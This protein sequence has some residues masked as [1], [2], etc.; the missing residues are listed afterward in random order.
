MKIVSFRSSGKVGHFLRAE[1]NR[2]GL[3]YPVPPRTSLLG[4]VGAIL[5]LEKD[6]P[7]ETL[8]GAALA[9][10]GRIP[11]I[12]WHTV[13]FRKDPPVPLPLAVK[14]TVNADKRI[15]PEKAALIPQEWLWCPDFIV[16]AALPDPYHD[17]FVSRL[18]E[19]RWHFSPCMGLSEMF[20]DITLRD[21]GITVAEPLER[22]THDSASVIPQQAG[23][24]EMDDAFRRGLAIQSLRM[25]CTVTP[26]RIF[27]H[28]SYYVERDGKP[29][30]FKTDKA[31]RVGREVVVFL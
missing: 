4:L 14:T 21:P 16:Y 25:P 12:H 26:D 19:R 31:W 3:T 9:L 10:R 15:A 20:A 8:R 6:S 7:Q 23:E 2:I 18:A 22:G 30:P 27:T 11:S 13:K 24:L 5:G 28:A 17:E 29:V 1:A